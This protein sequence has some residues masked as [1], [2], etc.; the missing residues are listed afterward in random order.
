MVL[1]FLAGA[2]ILLILTLWTVSIL[3]G[4]WANGLCGTKFELNVGITGIGTIAAAGATVYGI[5]R[6][7]QQKYMTDSRFNSPAAEKP[8]GRSINNNED[9][10]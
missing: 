5:A 1:I 10:N 6:A 4:F 2:W 3:L 9:S 8:A 7:A